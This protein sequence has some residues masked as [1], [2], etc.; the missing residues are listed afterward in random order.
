M[1]S[2]LIT[3][4]FGI[5]STTLGT[6]MTADQDGEHHRPAAE[7]DPGQCVAGEG[8]EEDPPGG[9][10]ERHDDGVLEP[11]REVRLREEPL[12]R[13]RVVK[14]CGIS[15]IGFAAASGSV[16]NDVATSTR[17]GQDVDDREQDQ[18][19]VQPPAGARAVMTSPSGPSAGTA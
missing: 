11:E 2:W 8:V 5:S 15:E 13:P 16:L 1:P 14:V 7:G 17:N 10:D 9:D 18:D 19:D 3:R 12:R 4:N 6:A